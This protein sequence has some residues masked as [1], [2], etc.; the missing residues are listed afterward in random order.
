MNADATTRSPKIWQQP[1]LWQWLMVVLLLLA[2]GL[3]LQRTG[4]R[5]VWWDEGWSV[6]VARQSVTEIVYQTG[7]TC[8]PRL[9]LV[10]TF[11]GRS[12]RRF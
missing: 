6:W 11:L 12:G 4:D 5:A 2:F 7:T 1:H 9:F 8:I 10:V 3:R